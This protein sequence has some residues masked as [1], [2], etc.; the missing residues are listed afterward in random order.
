M[1]ATETNSSWISEKQKTVLEGPHFPKGAQSQ[2]ERW[3]RECSLIY[4]TQNLILFCC[5]IST[6]NTIKKIPNLARSGKHLSLHGVID[7]TTI[8][9]AVLPG[10]CWQYK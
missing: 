5:L 1:A 8:V 4:D 2:Q 3:S 10:F 9:R 6:L 7:S